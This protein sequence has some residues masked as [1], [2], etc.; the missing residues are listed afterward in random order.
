MVQFLIS[1]L[2]TRTNKIDMNVL[3]SSRE[4]SVSESV[5][6]TVDVKNNDSRQK[7]LTASA[8][9]S[10]ENSEKEL[11]MAE[12]LNRAVKIRPREKARAEIK[13]IFN[14]RGENT[15]RDIHDS[16]P[17][18]R[19]YSGARDRNAISEKEAVSI[20]LKDTP[21]EVVKV[22]IDDGFYEIKVISDEGYRYKLYIDPERGKIMRKK[23]K[24]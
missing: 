8:D 16:R 7:E 17:M 14:E 21:G 20:A 15:A 3:A 1:S 12:Q 19:N 4:P 2:A 13:R 6:N 5:V 11:T 22:E 18:K 24:H 23:R 10:S 9:N